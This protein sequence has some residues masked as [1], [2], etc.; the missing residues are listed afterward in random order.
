MI[1]RKYP[2]CGFLAGADAILSSFGGGFELM[3]TGGNNDDR[4][5]IE[6]AAQ[7]VFKY[8]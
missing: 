1:W 4:P 5:I 7:Y 3:K 8:W 6:S 2:V